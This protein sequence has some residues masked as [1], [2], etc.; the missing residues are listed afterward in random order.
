MA[1]KYFTTLLDE[2]RLP[3]ETRYKISSTQ[4]TFLKGSILY[5]RRVATLDIAIET[6]SR[7]LNRPPLWKDL[8]GVI[9]PTWVRVQLMVYSQVVCTH[10]CNITVATIAPGT[11]RLRA[12]P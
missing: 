12:D 9:A 1:G 4:Q 8:E 11:P 7:K 2:G 5:T 3:D 10:F 6:N